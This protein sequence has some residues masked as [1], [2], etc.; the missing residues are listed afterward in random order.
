MFSYDGQKGLQTPKWLTEAV[1][2]RT[3]NATVA[4]NLI[5][6]RNNEMSDTIA[7]LN[8]TNLIDSMYE[9]ELPG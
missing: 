3:D 6:L 5:Q 2:R 8:R 7:F 4:R 9:I 1:D